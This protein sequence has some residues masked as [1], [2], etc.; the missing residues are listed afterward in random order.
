MVELL[1]N[2]KLDRVTKETLDQLTDSQRKVISTFAIATSI[3]KQKSLREKAALELQ[4]AYKQGRADITTMITALNQYFAAE[5]DYSKSVGDYQ[6][7][8]IEY[9]AMQ[10][11][12][13]PDFNSPSNKSIG[14]KL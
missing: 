6:T 1:E 14:D 13:I 2:T 3:K 5:V 4:K 7:A 12:L 11:E 9:A 8:L 10:D